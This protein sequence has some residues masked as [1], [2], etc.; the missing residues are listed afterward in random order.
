M[1]GLHPTSA[2]GRLINIPDI[3]RINQYQLT[4]EQQQRVAQIQQ[5]LSD[6]SL[7]PEQ[8]AQLESAYYSLAGNTNDRYME[9]RGG[10]N[11][12]GAKDA[13]KVFDKRTGKHVNDP[14]GAVTIDVDERAIAIRNN[15][16]LSRE[17]KVAQLKALGYN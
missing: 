17:Q 2:Q 8:R 1:P 10:T 3:G 5:Q 15:P 4:L 13:S 11:A 12:D 16:Q 7:A 14:Q 6:P 9:V